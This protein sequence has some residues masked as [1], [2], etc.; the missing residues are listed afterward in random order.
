MPAG[1]GVNPCQV[2]QLESGAF[3]DLG[4]LHLVHVETFQIQGF[5]GDGFQ[6][7]LDQLGLRQDERVGFITT[8][9]AVAIGYDFEKLTRDSDL[10]CSGWRT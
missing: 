4:Y 1:L 8:A 7:S 6:L 3:L 5:S 10:R 9:G 2:G